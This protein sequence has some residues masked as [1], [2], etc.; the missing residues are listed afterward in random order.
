MTIALQVQ[1]LGLL[2]RAMNRVEPLMRRAMVRAI[3]ASMSRAGRG[4]GGTAAK[5]KAVRRPRRSAAKRGYNE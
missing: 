1:G 4:A 2:K 5:I 3:N